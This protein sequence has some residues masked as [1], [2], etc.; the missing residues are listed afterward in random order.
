MSVPAPA[1]DPITIPQ[2]PVRAAPS[3]FPVMAAMAPVIVSV[4][5]WLVTRS[6]FALIFAALGPVIAIASV[7]DS[8]WSSGRRLKKDLAVHAEEL[9]ALT[10]RI[11]ER[12][13]QE[14]STR[15]DRR[16][17]ARALIETAGSANTIRR[18]RAPEQLRTRVVIGTGTL[19][20]EIRIEGFVGSDAAR[21]LRQRARLVTDVPVDIDAARGIGIVGTPT[22]ARACARGILVQ[23]CNAMAPDV[24]SVRVEGNGW[25]WTSALPHLA[26]EIAEVTIRVCDRTGGVNRGSSGEAG[27]RLSTLAAGTD[28]LLVVA[29]T[30]ESIPTSCRA[31]LEVTGPNSAVLH[32]AAADP[33]AAPRAGSTNAGAL[34]V[35]LMTM[36]ECEVFARSL[37]DWAEQLG[38]SNRA[39][40]LPSSVSFSE[41]QRSDRAERPSG[42]VTAASLSAAIGLGA[43]GP[44]TV[45]LVSDGP[46]AIIGG[47]TGSGK[48][49][50]LMTWIGSMASR[51]SP[52]DVTFLLV[53]F[54][55]GSAFAPLEP[56]PHVV[57]V[58]TDLD[59]VAAAR[60]L[61]SLSAEVLYRERVLSELGCRD[62][63]E[64]Q[65]A[66]PRL[67][68]VVDEFAAMLDG[69]G[70]LSALFV[71]LAA[72]GRSLG[73]H[74]ILCTQRPAG[75]MK[76]ALVANC[77]LRMSLRVH[78]RSDS[79]AV[80]GTD[81][82]AILSPAQ[83]GRLVVAVGGR[84]VPVQVATVTAGDIAEIVRT[85][86]V[87]APVRRPWLDPLPPR[88]ELSELPAADGIRLGL[89]DLPESQRQEVAV[90][91]PERD[92][93]VL[94]VGSSRSGKTTLLDTVTVEAAVGSE[95]PGSW[96][97][98]RVGTDDEETW[99]TV[100]GQAT[101]LRAAASSSRRTL[102]LIDDLDSILAR[103]DDDYATRLRD[104]VVELLRDGPRRSLWLM[105]T[106]QRLA[107][108]LGVLS[109]FATGLLVLRVANR[110][111][112]LMAG[113]EGSTWIP[114]RPPGNATWR[115]AT[116]QVAV[117]DTEPPGL[118]VQH[119]SGRHRANPAAPPY[120]FAAHALTLVVCPA[121]SRRAE[122]LLSLNRA[123]PGREPV[124]VASLAGA[125]RLTMAD[126]S[127][128]QPDPVV[129]VGD[130]DDWNNQWAL[131]TAVRQDAD[132]LLE[133][134]TVSE[135]RALTKR[136]ELPPLIAAPGHAWHVT[137]GGETRRVRLD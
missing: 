102:L 134:C 70:E 31:V 93:S 123:H 32:R 66:F 38:L 71:D 128:D 77:G 65:G 115:D 87:G 95:D 92:G 19:P 110:Q 78:D 120:D 80:V 73:M 67:V 47:T 76:D 81:A 103:L 55:G 21:A 72:R 137:P 86:P 63:G 13:E 7:I 46:H 133:G 68:I 91:H 112:H 9:A 104:A 4:L 97:L 10:D 50:L 54:K 127:L 116:V 37:A 27:S 88:V 6:P 129:L 29:D 106:T 83:P 41:V 43:N 64:T 59:E 96:N 20:S 15:R 74:L 122:A 101:A 69:F 119:R 57:G 53:D 75:V 108:S 99:D 22:L 36:A 62:I 60:A 100:I 45:D 130:S 105:L 8:R 82:A 90:W 35:E 125:T 117:A 61:A 49:E 52:Q 33:Q 2:R 94:V 39:A 26:A 24:A 30:V 132:V 109:G 14:R 111:E 5:I 118:H 18:W 114:H 17:G 3:P 1:D 89:A 12:L 58:L 28:I 135:Y 131:F 48:S 121:P 16:P 124:R 25:E 23:L 107:G 113:G 98:S 44:A 136:R 51:Y 56:L 34:R 11:D 79:I 40:A 126:L 42:S 84:I 85:A